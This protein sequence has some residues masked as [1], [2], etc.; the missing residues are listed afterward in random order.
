MQVQEDIAQHASD[1]LRGVSSWLDAENRFI[2][3]GL[4]RRFSAPDLVELRLISSLTLGLNK[5]PPGL[6]AIGR[7]VPGGFSV[8]SGFLPPSGSPYFT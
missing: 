6:F 3:L 1:R 5:S 7:T 2:E 8:V 4:L